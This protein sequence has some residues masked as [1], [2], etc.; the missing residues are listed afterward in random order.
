[1]G[2]DAQSSEA[3]KP[4]SETDERIERAVVCRACGHA[5]TKESARIDVDGRHQHTFV[6]AHAYAFTIAC[7]KDAPGCL[8]FGES[9][10]FWTWFEGHAWRIALCGGCSGHVGWSFTGESSF[11]GLVVDR[12]A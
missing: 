8:G 10:T 9:S 3:S 2:R 6:N 5:L 7:F 11:F 1:M 4:Q 12:I